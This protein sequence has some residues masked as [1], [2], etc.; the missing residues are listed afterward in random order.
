LIPRA[1]TVVAAGFGIAAGIAAA[2]ATYAQ[3]LGPNARSVWGFYPETTVVGRYLATVLPKYRVWVGGANFPRDTLIFLS[4]QGG[5]PMEA[6]FTWVEDITALMRASRIPPGQKG[7][8]FVLAID[9]PGRVVLAELQ[10][11]YPNHTMVDLRY[12]PEK[13][14]IFA[15]ALLVPPAGE[16]PPAAEPLAEEERVDVAD[17]DI[18]PPGKL[19]EPRGLTVL[20]D[21]TIVVCDFGNNRLQM[22]DRQQRFLRV[23]GRGGEG[24]SQF[25]QPGAVAVGPGDE[26]FVADTWNH[27]VQVFAKDGTFKRQWLSDF[28]SPRGIAVD[29][30]GNVVVADSGHNRV[31]RFNVNGDKL[32]EWNGS[33]NA[34]QFQEPIGIAAGADGRVY[35]SDVGNGRLQ[36]F[37]REGKAAGSFKVDGWL[38]QAYSEPHIAL[39]PS[40]RIWVTVPARREIRAYDSNGKLLR[41]VTSS[42]NQQASAGTPM[43]IAYDATTKTLLV[44]DLGGEMFRIRPD[45]REK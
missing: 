26:F 23:V 44:S 8:A 39:D 11:R 35:V 17:V 32:G 25:K 6:Q 42:S 14:R 5:D 10:R 30:E 13:G 34:G 12:P 33:E 38:S 31:V 9:G 18:G 43:G 36:I 45:E 22:F 2:V 16:E 20:S 27:R 19:Q 21:G 4:Y 41:T 1:G 3:Y 24:A 28:F 37:T 40:G 29:P 15:R 7:L